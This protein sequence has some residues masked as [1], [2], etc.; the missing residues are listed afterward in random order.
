MY[1]RRSLVPFLLA[2]GMIVGQG[3]LATEV[4]AQDA[5]QY[6]N[7][8]TP[9][10]EGPPFSDAV[11]VGNTLYLSGFLGVT[12]GQA[13]ITAEEEAR[14][15]LTNMRTRLEQ[16]GMT[17]D[18]LVSVQVYALGTGDYAV[19]NE[20]YRT[21]FTQE[22]PARAFVGVAALVNGARFEVGGI[23]VRR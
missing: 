5:R 22:F 11:L 17:M 13:P 18:D 16:A 8:R 4:F 15:V 1:S 2:T 21:F 6:V 9:S 19:F 7:P 3:L 12:A 23:A 14:A 10:T 20:V